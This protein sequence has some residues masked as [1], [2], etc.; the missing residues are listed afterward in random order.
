MITELVCRNKT[1]IR[2]QMTFCLLQ[3]SYD[4]ISSSLTCLSYA[5][6]R[7]YHLSLTNNQARNIKSRAIS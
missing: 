2:D 7:T 3:Q 5:H 1:V 4:L 6:F